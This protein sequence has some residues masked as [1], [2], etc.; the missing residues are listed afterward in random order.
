M[1]RPLKFKNLLFGI[2]SSTRIRHYFIHEIENLKKI[3]VGGG[4]CT[5]MVTWVVH[6]ILKALKREINIHYYLMISYV[7]LKNKSL[8][9]S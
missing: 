6:T 2:I 7:K 9:K 1:I 5:N 4:K 8:V 3:Y